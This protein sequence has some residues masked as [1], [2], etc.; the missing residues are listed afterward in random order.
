MQSWAALMTAAERKLNTLLK[1]TG[2][3]LQL[4]AA[5]LP[6]SIR[7]VFTVAYLFCRCADTVADT[8]LINKERKEF[9]IESFPQLFKNSDISALKELALEV[10][11]A[12]LHK[13]ERAL[14]EH[15]DICVDVFNTFTAED[16]ELV[17]GIVK[18]V[19]EGMLFDLNKFGAELTT[20]KTVDELEY[21]CDTMGGAPGVFWSRL[22]LKCTAVNM[23]DKAFVNKGRNIGRALQIVNILRDFT[24]DLNIGRVYFP[25]EDLEKFDLSITDI[26]AGKSVK[27]MFFKWINWGVNHIE[28]APEFYSAMGRV[29]WRLRVSVAWPVIWTLDNFILLSC[30]NPL[31]QK[32]R[33]NKKDIYKTMFLSPLYLISNSVFKSMVDRRIKK[34]RDI[35]K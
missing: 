3:T 2:R 1:K 34:I 19:C 12:S 25:Q 30:T 8:D 17:I 32:L 29:N 26:C 22:I 23:E 33:I 4:S 5:V 18:K 31:K 10:N 16:K 35:T 21:Y 7:W 28:A 9:W 11:S 20:L 6:E 24:H 27:N 13:D 14:L 15:I